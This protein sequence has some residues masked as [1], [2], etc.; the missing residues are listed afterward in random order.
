[1]DRV[2]SLLGLATRAGMTQSG[3]FLTEE[4][5]RAGNAKLVLI[6]EDAQK[7]TRKTIE[8]KCRFRNVPFRIYGTKEA[9]GRAMGKE[10]RSCT[11]VCDAG[12]A[13]GIVKIID[14]EMRGNNGKNENQ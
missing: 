13:A 11:A 8:D 14:S 5:A 10:L 1:M 4:A 2:Y 7:N 9:L 12:F 3:S 6:A